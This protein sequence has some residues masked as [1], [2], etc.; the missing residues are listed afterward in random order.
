MLD[1]LRL[2]VLA[3]IAEHGSVTLAATAF[4]TT[5]HHAIQQTAVSD[6]SH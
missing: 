3:A 2:Q 6:R 4:I 1:I 5:L